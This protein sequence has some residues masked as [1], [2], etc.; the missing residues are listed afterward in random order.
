MRPLI[1]IIV[2]V[3]NT[4]AYLAKCLDSLLAQSYNNI[5][6]MV[7][8]DGST[9]GSRE[10]CD[11]YKE[12]DIRVKVIHKTNGGLSSARNAGLFKATGD[13]ISFVDSDDYVAKTYIEDLLQLIKDNAAD[14]SI[15]GI[16]AVNEAGDPIKANK[17]T[18]ETIT[19]TS[20][21]AMICQFYQ[22]GIGNH[23][24]GKL[25]SKKC[26]DDVR[27][28]EDRIYEDLA[29]VYKFFSKADKIVKNEQPLYFYLQRQAS[30]M[31]AEYSSKK[32]DRIYV[33][34]EILE[35]AKNRSEAL[36]KAAESRLFVSA[37][38]VLREIPDDTSNYK[39]EMNKITA[40]IDT[41][42]GKV[43]KDSNAKPVNRVIA[44]VSMALRP[45]ALKKFGTLYKK[46][47]P[48]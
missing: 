28:P 41:Y 5:E 36:T 11:A 27:F 2:P 29:T 22:K 18:E 17:N 10:I 32:M 34:E 47:Y 6:I 39:E 42:K 35:F 4:E 26:F 12:K 7:V 20:E 16:L 38:Q 46:V 40:I 19:Y 33:S 3:Y 14:I 8:D 30:I 31:H 44:G 1:S 9:D 15:C 43:L 24:C 48:V 13:Y 37:V 45:K 23:A 25:Y 21:E